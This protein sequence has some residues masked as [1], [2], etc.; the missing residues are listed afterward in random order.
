MDDLVVFLLS[1]GEAV[2]QVLPNRMWSR[3]SPQAETILSEQHD[4]ED[5]LRAENN[6]GIIMRVGCGDEVGARGAV[7]PFLLVADSGDARRIHS[8]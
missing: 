8:Q 6:G 7:V 5:R 4:P 3:Q 1:G 2:C